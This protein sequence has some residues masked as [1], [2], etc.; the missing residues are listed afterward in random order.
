M[1][2]KHLLFGLLFIS[3]IAAQAQNNKKEVLFTIDGKPY[4]TDEFARVYKKNLDLV[5]DESQKDLNQYLELFVGYKLKINK[6]FKLGL[7]NGQQYQ[8]EL[9]QYRTQLAKN[10]TTDSKVTEELVQEAYDRS[11]KEIRA[12]HILIMV[13]ENAAPADTLKAYKQAMDIR[14]KAINGEDFGELAVKYSQDPSAKE[15]KGDLGYF[16]SLRM[17]YA[18]EGAAYKTPVG[19]I[20]NPVRTRFGYHLIKVNDVRDNRGEVEVAHIMIMADPKEGDAGKAK[21]Q[22]KIKDISKKLKQGESFEALAKQFSEDKSSASKGGVLNRFGSGQLSSEAFENQ[23]FSL[24]NPGDVSEPFESQF[25]WHI[26]KLIA[27]YPVKPLSEVK[28]ELQNKISKDERSRLIAES[29][30]TKLKKKYK[31]KR[32]DKAYAA[33]QKAVTDKFY[34]GTW[35]LKETKPYDGKLLTIEDKTYS[36]TDFINFIKSQQKAGLTI[37]PVSRLVD[38]LYEQFLDQK[39]NAYYDDNLEKEFPEFSLVMDEYRDG[40]LLFDLMEKEIWDKSKTDTIGLKNYYEGHKSAYNWKTRLDATVVSS[41]KMD[42]IK[43]AQKFLKQGKSSDFIKEKLNLNG[44]VNVM[45]NSGTFE[46]GTEAVPKGIKQT[47]G[48]SDIV[49]DGDYFFVVKVNKVLPAGPKTLDEAKGKVIND[50][51]QYLEENWVKDLRNEFVVKVNQD[52]FDRV[53]KELQP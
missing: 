20:S 53:K 5:K 30:T 49:K 32:D 19:K 45:A 2:M 31:I 14:Q 6:A 48:V 33:V 36:G 17:V 3:N 29:M 39:L 15:N 16:T 51:Q 52:V 38:H 41:T 37:K 9:R 47:V 24:K 4:Y 50:Y 40:L 34:E 21:A 1:K 28:P 10:Y 8:N 23:A 11:L 27:K 43:S 35:E 46:E 44:I 25:G 12:S 42:V 13:D 18:F 26:V 7:Q 22:E